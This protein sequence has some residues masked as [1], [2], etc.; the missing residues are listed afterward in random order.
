ME[1]KQTPFAIV[2]IVSKVTS[3]VISCYKATRG[4]ERCRKVCIGVLPAHRSSRASLPFSVSLVVPHRGSTIKHT[5]LF[6][7]VNSF[8]RFLFFFSSSFFDLT[9]RKEKTKRSLD[10]ESRPDVLRGE[11]CRAKTRPLSIDTDQTVTVVPHD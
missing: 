11:A 1:I 6:E 7:F 9:L 10:D 3:P 5:K 8:P 4:S 2:R